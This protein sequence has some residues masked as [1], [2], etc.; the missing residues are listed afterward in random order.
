MWGET[1]DLLRRYRAEIT[2]GVAA[3][4]FVM[5][6]SL[7]IP[8]ARG[9]TPR[10]TG[11]VNDY[12]GVL[13]PV[14]QKSLESRL[15]MIDMGKPGRPQVVVLVAKSLN[16]ETIERY[17]TDTFHAWRLGDKTRDNGVLLV[18]APTER[19]MRIEV[20]YGLE[21]KLPDVRAKAIL[22]S[23]KPFL[24]KGQENWSA[25]I[26]KGVEGISSAIQ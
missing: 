9:E 24:K 23:M 12:A 16:G 21:G 15:S 14:Q 6:A 26:A 22:D 19:R 7:V 8:N 3:L 20:G 17:A 2:V 11:R 25:A 18:L 5:L 1:K 13:T 4:L 10:L